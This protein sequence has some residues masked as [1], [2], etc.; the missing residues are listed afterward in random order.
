MEEVK[1]IKDDV[2]VF[3]SEFWPIA[4][5]VEVEACIEVERIG[6]LCLSESSRGN[7]V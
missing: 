4:N 7:E 6:P 3:W 1:V 5:S 2:M